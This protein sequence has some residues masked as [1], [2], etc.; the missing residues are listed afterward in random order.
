MDEKTE[1]PKGGPPNANH[2]THCIE[3]N[4]LSAL[5]LSALN[6][7]CSRVRA[8]SQRRRGA[9]G[10]SFGDDVHVRLGALIALLLL[11][12][13]FGEGVAKVGEQLAQRHVR[14]L[15]LLSAPL[16]VHRLPGA[17]RDRRPRAQQAFGERHG[18]LRLGVD[19]R[20]R[21]RVGDL[22]RLRVQL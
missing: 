9:S 14:F 4:E 15:L 8:P 11:V 12:R 6:G 18:A 2:Q 3:T 5:M 1:E 10:V 7:S 20:L 21:V 19:E 22:Y 13:A 17:A 16:H